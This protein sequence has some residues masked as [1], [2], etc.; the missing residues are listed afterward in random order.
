MQEDKK[1]LQKDKF[2]IT[3]NYEII[4]TRNKIIVGITKLLQE[5]QNYCR[6]KT[7][8]FILIYNLFLCKYKRFAL[9]INTN[10]IKT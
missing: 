5:R 8:K 3:G 10:Y 2:F 4:N 7:L 9:N 1:L 6:F